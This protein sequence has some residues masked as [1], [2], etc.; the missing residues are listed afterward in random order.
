MA[1]SDDPNYGNL[2]QCNMVRTPQEFQVHEVQAFSVDQFV[3]KLI[4]DSGCQRNCC[5]PDWHEQNAR[6]LRKHGLQVH[7]VPCTDMFQFG[8]GEPLTAKFRSYVPAG[9]AYDNCF[10]LGVAIVDAE[11]PLLG[12]HQLLDELG[13]IIDIPQKM[14]HLQTLNVSLPLEKIAGHLTVCIDQFP[15]DVNKQMKLLSHEQFWH[16]PNPNCLLP[17]TVA[18]STSLRDQQQFDQAHVLSAANMADS[19]E[20]SRQDP[21]QLQEGDLHLHGK[22]G[23]LG[24]HAQDLAPGSSSTGDGAAPQPSSLQPSRVPPLQQRNRA[25]RPMPDVRT[26][27]EVGQHTTRLARF[28][29]IAKLLYTVATI[30]T[31]V[32]DSNGAQVQAEGPAFSFDEDFSPRHGGTTHDWTT[33]NAGTT[34]DLGAQH[35]SFGPGNRAQ[36]RGSATGSRG[37]HPEHGLLPDGTSTRPSKVGSTRHGGSA[38]SSSSKQHTSGAP[39]G[40]RALRLGLSRRLQHTLKNAVENYEAESNIY[41]SLASVSDRPPPMIDIFELFSGSSKFTKMAHRYGLNALQPFDIKHG[42]HQDLK[43]PQVQADVL[44]AVKKFKP[45]FVIMGLDC[46]L[47]NI[48]N[49]NL[50]YSHRLELLQELQD[51]E[52]PLVEFACEVALLQM[53][54]GRYFLMENPQR[55]RLWSLPCITDLENM[56]G[57]WKTTLDAGAF[58]AT[59]HQQPVAK[60]MTF[61]GNIPDMDNLIHKRLTTEERSH[62]TPIQGNMTRPSQ[63]YPDDLVK[64]M[65]KH[66]KQ[67]VQLRE[68]QRFNHHQVLAVAQPTMD[69]SAWDDI[70]DYVNGVFERSSKRPFNI[71]PDSELGKKINDLVRMDT[72]RIQVAP[73]PTTRRLPTNAAFDLGVTHR[74]ALLQFNDGRRAL[75][76]ES[77]Q[78][79]QLPKQRFDKP[80]KTAIFMFGKMRD[81]PD[82]QPTADDTQPNLPIPN[83]PTDITFPNLPT[84][85]GINLETRKTVARLH[86]NL[87]H[88]SPQELTRMVAYYGG[89]PSSV[90]T[91]IQ[92]LRCATCDR[93]KN[94]QQPRPATMPKFTAGQ[95]GDEVQGDIFYVRLLS[96]EAIPILG[97]VDKA[98]G[99]HQAAVCQTRNSAETF[100]IFRQCWLQPFGLPYKVMLDPDPTFRGDFQSHVEHLGIICD[101]CPAEAHWVIGMIERRNAVLRCVLEKLIDQFAV[102]E[103]NVLEN[104][105]PAALHAVNSSTFTRGRTAYQAVFGRIPRLPGGIFNDDTAITSS[106]M[107]IDGSDNLLAKAEIIRSEAQKHLIDLNCS[108]QLRRALLRKTKMTKFP[109]LQPGQNC[110]YWRW[111]RKGQKK[112]GA[113]VIARFLSWDPS[114]PMK[115]AWLQTGAS[116]TLVS[117]EQLRAATGFEG[118]NPSA[119]DVK[120]LKSGIKSFRDHLLEDDT[121]PPAPEPTFDEAFTIDTTEQPVSLTALPPPATPQQQQQPQAAASTPLQLPPP[122]ITTAHEQSIQLNLQQSPTYRQTNIYQRFG[123]P[124]TPRQLTPTRQ[125]QP[126]TTPHKPLRGRSRSPAPTST[127]RLMDYMAEPAQPVSRPEA[128]S[129]PL[130]QQDGEEKPPGSQPSSQRHL[131]QPPLTP[132]ELHPLSRTTTSPGMSHHHYNQLPPVNLLHYLKDKINHTYHLLNSNNSRQR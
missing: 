17:A 15:K 119:E 65:L 1:V 92:H 48:F 66:M 8:K 16:D 125:D 36:P 114:A 73:T 71:D 19:M 22:S 112:R 39:R 108:Q 60:P 121:G 55:S 61:M 72:V 42:P 70:L 124:P 20:R 58:G 123:A 52:L 49:A 27:V 75:E 26:Q 122:N 76:L 128:G 95:F 35:G 31:A 110:A 77:L 78:D 57:T 24:N 88:P 94:V 33:L 29:W 9:V 54:H 38:A 117:A 80:V 21:E 50:N 103:V 91:C 28:P 105:L 11:V 6:M 118:W 32:L 99:F 106:P 18:H 111:Q 87:G 10:L 102:Y 63:E 84:G 96:T 126:T 86:L 14:L 46:R 82:P 64:V 53:K 30:A 85:H 12:S 68:P 74:A 116:T 37:H 113:W 59:V 45:W 79:L 89:A 98:T 5:G 34:Y 41:H 25:L 81:A 56:P 104:I 120:A 131:H 101:F 44:K 69:L 2:F 130:V 97:L 3:G 4:V 13:A 90:T 132:Q 129:Q 109:D 67:L 51:A 115:L 100:T 40:G 127:Q 83:L 62:C 7:K 93:L 47:W 43:D 107:V 23:N